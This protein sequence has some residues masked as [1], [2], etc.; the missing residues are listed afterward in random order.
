M[1]GFALSNNTDCSI[2]DE[3][4]KYPFRAER[5]GK[6]MSAL[7]TS[8][9]Y[10]PRHIIEKVPW[11]SL[12]GE[13]IIDIGGAHGDT[14]LAIA[15]SNP[16]LKIIVQDLQPVI[17]SRPKFTIDLEDRV[18]FMAHD[19]FTEQPIKNA[20]VYL[21]R[22]IFHNW[23][24]KYCLL[25]L[26]NLIPA[27]KPNARIII[28]DVCLPEPNTLSLSVERQIRYVALSPNQGLV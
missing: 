18:T 25:I 20:A 4:S 7:I 27:L 6:G 28:N 12:R 2:Y 22:W 5:L 23:S 1:K 9:G 17:E 15:K 14:A 8:E 11:A 21:F 24:D 26:R 10:E 16:S 13:T 19:F 3:I